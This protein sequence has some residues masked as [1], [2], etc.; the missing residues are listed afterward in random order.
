MKTTINQV[1]NNFDKEEKEIYKNTKKSHDFIRCMI[2]RRKSLGMTQKELAEKT[3]LTQQAVSSMER[4]DRR[5]TLVNL[6]KY[7]DGIEVNIL[8]IFK[9]GK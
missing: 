7:L 3:G 6:I 4:F 9:E 2:E 1:I 8:D 5:P